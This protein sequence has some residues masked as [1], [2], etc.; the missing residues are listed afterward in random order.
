ME[1]TVQTRLVAEARQRP[2]KSA[3]RLGIEFMDSNRLLAA[4][5]MGTFVVL[6][7]LQAVPLLGLVASVAMGVF[8]QAVQIYVGRA[9]YGAPDI[10]AYVE[11]A[12]TTPLKDFL[13][14]FQAPAFGAWLGWIAVWIGM[15][16]V[17]VILFSAFGGS[18][19]M[20][21]EATND[22]AQM[23]QMLVASSGAMLPI[24]LVFFA[25]LY[26]YPIVQGRITVS[27]TF[28]EAFKAVFTLFSPDVWRRSMKKEYFSFVF[29][30]GLAMTGIWI[31]VMA[32]MMLLLLIPFLGAVLVTVWL[33]F[34]VYVFIM[35]I[36]VANMIAYDIAYDEVL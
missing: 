28:G 31:L 11:T 22:E 9:F 24:L 19:E 26:V 1:E 30:F 10:L 8:S 13:T 34:L 2:V 15:M 14:R 21:A 3:L 12:K 5:T 20:M 23:Q 27:D 25:L 33:M 18:M 36:S 35:V 29:F 32:V 17:F 7:L 16:I 6:T 4:M